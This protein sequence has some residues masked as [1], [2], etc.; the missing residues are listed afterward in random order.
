MLFAENKTLYEVKRARLVTILKTAYPEDLANKLNLELIKL[1][2]LVQ[3]QENN[4]N[5]R[6]G[7]ALNI[8]EGLFPDK[9]LI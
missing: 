9:E 2:I 8:E 6:I 7:A 3:T 4:Y 5:D 1:K